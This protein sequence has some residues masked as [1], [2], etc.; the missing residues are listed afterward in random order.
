MTVL[1]EVVFGFAQ[2]VVDDHPAVL[3]AVEM[4]ME[5]AV[6]TEPEPTRILRIGRWRLRFRDGFRFDRFRFGK[7]VGRV[8]LDGIREPVLAE[9]SP[10]LPHRQHRGEFGDAMVGPRRRLGD[11][12]GHL[13]EGQFPALEQLHAGG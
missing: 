2:G 5:A 9:N 1:E 13:I 12:G 6:V 4:Q 10:E 7:V 3:V 8:R 11:D